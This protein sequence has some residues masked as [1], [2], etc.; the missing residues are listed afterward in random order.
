MAHGRV[1][2]RRLRYEAGYFHR[3]G[4]NARTTQTLGA[5]GT[6]AFRVVT[7]PFAH[8]SDTSHSRIHLGF[9]LAESRLDN[10]LGLRGRTLLEDGVF[11][12]RVSVNGHRRRVGVEAFWSAGPSSLGGEYM[13]VADERNEM[14]LRGDDL[15]A[16]RARAWYVAATWAAT[17]KKKDGRLEP[18]RP[19]AI[20]LV[21]RLE[22]LRF[23]DVSHP[24]TPFDFP[25]PSTL[26]GNADLVTTLGINLYLKRHVRVQYNHVI[27]AIADAQRSPAPTRLGRFATGV[28]RVQFTL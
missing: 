23:Q 16:V 8:G 19:F 18:R 10:R 17:G 4:D 3:D 15:P 11:F 1:F 25:N 13:L 9:A 26:L 7:T 24:R 20:E 22:E 27:E 6:C 28:L 21:A 12:D 2:G 14:G 5:R